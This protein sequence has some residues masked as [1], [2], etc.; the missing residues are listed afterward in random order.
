MIGSPPIRPAP[1]SASAPEPPWLCGADRP[2][3]ILPAPIRRSSSSRARASTFT[4]PSTCPAAIGLCYLD[5]AAQLFWP[6]G[7]GDANPGDDVDFDSAQIPDPKCK[8]PYG[9]TTNLKIEKSA[10]PKVC[11]DTG[12]D[13]KCSFLVTVTNTGPGAYS[14]DI[15]VTDTLSIP[16]PPTVSPPP[17]TCVPAGPSYTCTYPGAA[18]NPGDSIDMCA[19]DHRPQGRLEGRGQMLG[20]E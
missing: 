5:N 13:W 20:D 14:G 10:K 4:S 19:D 2:G 17:W 3:R 1:S 8:P 11:E 15:E 12:A 6:L 7:Y 9:D 16:N 18:L